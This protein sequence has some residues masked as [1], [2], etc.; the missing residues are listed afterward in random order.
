MLWDGW[1]YQLNLTENLF[2]YCVKRVVSDCSVML[3]NGKIFQTGSRKCNYT[4]DPSEPQ[5]EHGG[6]IVRL[7]ENNLTIVYLVFGDM[8]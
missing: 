3:Y 5:L 7:M 8:V 6:D 1:T 4:N 2:I